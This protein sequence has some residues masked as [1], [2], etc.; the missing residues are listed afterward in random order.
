MV[1]S[2]LLQ[3]YAH[4]TLD[5][6]HAGDNFVRQEAYRLC[7]RSGGAAGAKYHFYFVAEISTDLGG[8]QPERRPAFYFQQ[9]RAW[10]I[11]PLNNH[12]IFYRFP[13]WAGDPDA[14]PGSFTTQPRKNCAGDPMKGLLWITR[15]R[16]ILC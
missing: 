5:I 3:T 7:H 9:L 10:I 14:K 11:V 15:H 4:G 8:I 6:P 16:K 13:F 1:R 2:C 12:S